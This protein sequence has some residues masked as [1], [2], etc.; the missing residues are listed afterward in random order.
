MKYII[1]MEET[2][3]L[4]HYWEKCVGSCHAA[5]ALRSDYRKQLETAHREL[6][7]EYVRFH[8]LFDDDM[9]VV[10]PDSI[11]PYMPSDKVK[12]NFMNTDNIFDFLVSIG[13]K[14]FLELG[15]MPSLLASGTEKAFAFYGGN[16]TMP[17]DFDQWADFIEAFTRHIE[18]RYGSKEV[19]TWFFEVWNE[20]NLECF[21]AGDMDTYFK[22]YEYTTRA[23]KKVNPNFLVGG[24]ATSINAWI[25]E[26]R[27]YCVVHDV[28]LDFIST[29]HY[30][31]DDPL[32]NNP[33]VDL[34][35]L[36]AEKGADV[37]SRY[38]KHIMRK[39][40]QRA[41]EECGNLPLYY[42]EWNISAMLGEIEHDTPYAASMIARILHE[43]IGLVEG[44]S[45]WTFTDIFEEMGQ[46]L[47]EFHGG[48]GLQTYHGIKK[49]AYR[50]FELFHRLGDE[51]CMVEGGGKDDNVGVLASK[52]GN[53][54]SII[55][56]NHNTKAVDDIK[57]ESVKLSFTDEGA[58]YRAEI[59]MVDEVNAN[60]RLT[61]EEMGMPVYVN[62]RQIKEL[63]A[64]SALSMKPLEV[65]K[66]QGQ[67]EISLDLLP[68]SM[69]YL[70]IEQC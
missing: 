70:E 48:F 65:V 15:F 40:T 28:P 18:E 1:H 58:E 60:P 61:W 24:P 34:M 23:V 8:G 9:S 62:N 31:T 52:K 56:Y 38:D 36:I 33:E 29:H 57:K 44:Y 20:P 13:M 55:V 42:T 16:K 25:P 49:P 7:F 30:P 43:N 68:Y 51:L 54:L 45:Y 19:E 12:Y 46:M 66:T 35:Q 47:G 53:K 2:K 67:I 69:A 4:K 21:W 14:P 32:W 41:K 26:F 50:A 22:L 10:L 39:M 64:A 37:M 59:C 6:G 27:K 3:P 11:S 17:K 5:T 63:E